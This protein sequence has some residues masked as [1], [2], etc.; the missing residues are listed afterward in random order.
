MHSQEN[1]PLVR[2]SVVL[3]FFHTPDHLLCDDINLQLESQLTPGS[4]LNNMGLPIYIISCSCFA[5][6][7]IIKLQILSLVKSQQ[8]V[9][10][11]GIPSEIKR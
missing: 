10:D 8:L 9:G 1:N 11:W 4:A 3:F 2:K 5:E 7:L 6:S